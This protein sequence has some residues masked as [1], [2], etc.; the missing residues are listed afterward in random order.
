MLW[1]AE[2]CVHTIS[3]VSGG[4]FF[5]PYKYVQ[6][7]CVL[8]DGSLVGCCGDG[9][10]KVWNGTTYAV[11]RTLTHSARTDGSQIVTCVCTLPDG[12]HVASGSVDG[13]LKVWDVASGSMTVLQDHGS[14]A[15]C[16]GIYSL[17]ALPDGRLVSGFLDGT[18]KVWAKKW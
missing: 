18:V 5:S 16:N 15:Q 2:N 10:V 6:G 14:G 9:T 1:R 11:I 8:A 12:R 7:V 4:S 3:S 13:A 17:C